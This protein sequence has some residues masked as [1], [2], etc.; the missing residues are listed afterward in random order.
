MP[1]DLV[2][3]ADHHRRQSVP[4]LGTADPDDDTLTSPVYFAAAGDRVSGSPP[5]TPNVVRRG[6]LLTRS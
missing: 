4:V 5:R 2:A 3:H 1:H 6:R